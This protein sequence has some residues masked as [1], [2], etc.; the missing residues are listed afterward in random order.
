MYVFQIKKKSITKNN[1]I[2][3]LFIKIVYLEFNFDSYD[4]IIKKI[5]IS[6]EISIVIETIL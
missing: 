2:I 5:L 3:K 6:D 1:M 4:Y